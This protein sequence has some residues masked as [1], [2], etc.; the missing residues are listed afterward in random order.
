MAPLFAG[1]VG[2]LAFAAARLALHGYLR[3]ASQHRI[4]DIPNARSSHSRVTPRGG[5]ILFF[6]YLLLVAGWEPALRILALCSAPIALVGFLDD[7]R[8][9]PASA[10]LAVHVVSAAVFIVLCGGSGAA[11]VGL[12]FFLLVFATNTFNF[13]DGIDGLL[14]G[15]SATGA[16]W[17]W[18]IFQREGG[19]S[20]YFPLLLPVL[21]AFLL[22][23]WHP[24]RIFMGD[25]GSGFLGFSLATAVVRVSAGTFSGL[26]V[27]ALVF[28][29]L[30]G[31][32]TLTLLAR[33]LRRENI[34]QAHRSHAYQIASLSRGEHSAIAALYSGY[35][36]VVSG[37]LAYGYFLGKIPLPAAL[38]AAY[39]PVFAFWSAVKIGAPE[40]VTPVRP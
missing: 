30:C 11:W 5:G 27:F 17:L 26:F 4:L 22:S 40:A 3:F 35:I 16:I 32:A 28:A 8:G 9:V 25:V 10:R 23:N 38:A 15:M 7:L 33:A 2:L 31:D 29:P 13:I 21:L 20:V 37:P 1:I 12:A 24:A 18:L 6:P 39:L 19:T 14:A 36:L 34:F